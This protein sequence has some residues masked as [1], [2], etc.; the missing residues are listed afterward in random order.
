MTDL[1]VIPVDPRQV[2]LAWL[3]PLLPSILP[4]WRADSEM[5]PGITP[6]KFILVKVL[7]GDQVSNI[8]DRV[9]V[10]FQC[11]GDNGITDD[12]MRSRAA[13]IISAHAHRGVNARRA[14]AVVTLPD[15]TDRIRSI[16]QITMTALLRGEDA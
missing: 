5:V 12:A 15:P 8:A 1:A 13:R 10:V 14:S 9:V 11:W 3:Q 6:S 16:S 7:G 4:G 2:L